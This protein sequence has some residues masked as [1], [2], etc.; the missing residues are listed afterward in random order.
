MWLTRFAIERRVTISMFIG[1][2]IVLGAVGLGEMPWDLFPSIDIPIVLV[3]VPYPGAGPEEIEQRIVRK[4]EDGLSVLEGLDEI[5]A[6]AQENMGVVVLSFTEQTQVD[7]AAA[8]VR[9]AIGRVRAEFPEGAEEPVVVKADPGSIPVITVGL[10]GERSPRD[11]R[12]LVEDTIKPVFGRVPGVASISITGGEEREIRVLISEQRLQAVGLTPTALSQQLR[13]ENLD[14]PAGTMETGTR[15]FRVRVLGELDDLEELRSLPLD[16]PTG[17]AVRLGEIAEIQDTVVDPSGYARIDGVPSVAVEVV[18]RPDANTVQVVSGIKRAIDRF[19]RELPGDLEFTISSDQSEPVIE[20]IIDLRNAIMW[21]ALF[22]AL[23]VFFFLHNFRGM[24]IVAVAIPTSLLATFLPIGL[25]FGFTLNMMVMLG[26]ALSVGVLIDDSVVVLENIQR[27]LEYGELPAQAALNG[28]SEIGAA[29][30]AIT[31]VDVVVYLPVALM[32]GIFGQVFYSFGITV[33]VCVLFS[34]IMAFTLTPMLSAW[35]YERETANHGEPRGL[36]AFLAGV[37]GLWDGGYARLSALYRRVAR[38]CVAHPYLTLLLGYALLIAAGLGILRRLPNEFF[39]ASDQRQV[40][41]NIETPLG[42]RLEV[43]DEVVRGIEERLQD[44]QKYPEVEHVYGRSGS[45]GQTILGIGDVGPNYGAVSLF[46]TPARERKSGGLRSD[47]ELAEDLRN[48]LADVPSAELHVSA[49]GMGPGHG[50][51]IELVLF[52]D[53][54]D[55]LLAK[56]EEVR[57]EV[58]RIEGLRDVELSTQAGRP[59]VQIE[60]DR[61][62]AADKG[63]SVAQIAQTIRNG[64]AGATD[65]K[66]RVGG[67]EYDIRVQLPE[68]DRDSLEKIARLYLGLTRDDAP[69]HVNDVARVTRGTGPTRIERY[70]RER[71]VTLEAQNPGIGTRDATDAIEEVLADNELGT[72]GW[73]WTGATRWQAEG[74]R[75]LSK[76]AVLALLLMYMVTAAL[77]NSLLEPLNVILI[78]PIALVGGGI[79]LW[80]AGMSMSLVAMIGMIMLM[81]LVAKNSILVVDYTNTLRARGMARAEALVEAGATRMQPV[82]MT[83]LA[84]S[85]GMLPTALALAEGSEWRAPMAVVVIFGLILSTPVSL[86]IV[87]ASYMVWDQVGSFFTRTARRV[88]GLGNTRGRNNRPAARPGDEG[89]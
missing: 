48:D 66:Y 50:A 25:G 2:L 31:M 21:G 89:E 47:Q 63:M 65:S 77:Y 24:V 3:V 28:R 84:A 14:L 11:L 35:W 51:P 85:L 80:L 40:S 26:L 61:E 57:Q 78:V 6:S 45:A 79:G 1:I 37:F 70:Q 43:T 54:Y 9:D 87:P 32:E 22:A 38:V 81:G 15:D 49:Q 4:L 59:E 53:D 36:N 33:V 5:E 74:M 71:S 56:A 29:A 88:L 44:R 12:K 83:T 64:I 18:K 69:V 75:E 39:P 73:S 16:T 19:E 46:L 76:A 8:D 17:G 20:A 55:A 42:T 62:L 72:I 58:A 27:H 41:I 67:D 10:S 23:V 60:I 86:L 52:S 82:F 13:L 30:I 7:V 68:L 34:L